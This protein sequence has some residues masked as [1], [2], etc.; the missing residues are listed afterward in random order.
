VRLRRF[1]GVDE[2]LADMEKQGIGHSLKRTRTLY[3]LVTSLIKIMDTHV[4]YICYLSPSSRRSFLSNAAAVFLVRRRS[5]RSSSSSAS[6][7]AASTASPA[8][9]A[10]R[11]PRSPTARAS[12]SSR[13]PASSAATSRPRCPARLS[14]RSAPRRCPTWPRPARRRPR[15]AAPAS[16]PG[17]WWSWSWVWCPRWCS[18]SGRSGGSCAGTAPSPQVRRRRRSTRCWSTRRVAR[19]VL[20]P[21]AAALHQGVQGEA[22]PRQVRRRV[23]RRAGEP[24]GGGG[25]AAGRDRTGG[26]AVPDGGGHHQQKPPPQPGPPHRLL[27]RGPAPAAGQPQG[28]PPPD[29]H[30]RARHQGLPG[31]GVARQPAHHGQ[32]RRVQLRDGAAGDRQRATQLR[33]VEGDAREEVLGVDVRGVREGQPRRHHR[34]EAPRRGPRHGAG[35]ARSAGKLLVHPGGEELAEHGVVHEPRRVLGLAEAAPG[36]FH[37]LPRR[38]PPP[39]PARGLG[40]LPPEEVLG[41]RLVRF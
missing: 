5:P 33:R 24:D 6:P 30:Q 31:A 14:S 17:S 10:S 3:Y 29:A 18:A 39:F 26:E 23:P 2:G 16:A 25:E 20:V 19:A 27:L 35:G 22:G 13:C 28:P 37:E 8:A 38:R 1:R 34:Q 9:P 11:P 12:A 41:R 4:V 21:Q 36:V 15:P 32:V 40:E 7:P